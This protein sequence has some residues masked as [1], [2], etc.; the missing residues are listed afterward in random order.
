MYYHNPEF[1]LVRLTRDEQLKA[2]QFLVEKVNRAKGQITVLV[3]LGG[4]SIMDKE[5]GA[6]WEPETNRLCREALRD[7]LNSTIRYCEV[8]A[9]INDDAFADAAFDEMMRAMQG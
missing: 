5:G 4:G 7:G 6:F 8:E 9:H 2:T 3:P 1:T